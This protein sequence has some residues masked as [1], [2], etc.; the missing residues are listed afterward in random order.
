MKTDDDSESIQEDIKSFLYTWLKISTHLEGRRYLEEHLELLDPK[1]D[2]LIE[3]IIADPHTLLSEFKKEGESEQTAEIR[4]ILYTHKR[5]LYDA[6]ERGSTV[7]AV[8]AAYVNFYS[9]FVLDV[10]S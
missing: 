10:P 6:R 5:L 3:D 2:A 4:Q 7:V 8:R 9:G 1:T